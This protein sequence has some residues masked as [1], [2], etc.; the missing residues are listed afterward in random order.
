MMTAMMAMGD[1]DNNVDGDGVMGSEV[2]DDGDGV[3]GDDNDDDNDGDD[4]D[5]GDRRQ[6]QRQKSM[7]MAM[8]Q[9]AM[10]SKMMVTA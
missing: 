5:D 9:R 10:R 6:G 3:T 1:G 7:T 8:A 2:D 4:G